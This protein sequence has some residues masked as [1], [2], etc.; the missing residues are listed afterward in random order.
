MHHSDRG[1]QYACPEYVSALIANNM[2]PSMY[3]TNYYL[4][5]LVDIIT[6]AP[7]I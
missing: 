5:Q 3:Q 2:V 4:E 7:F 6:N 1:I